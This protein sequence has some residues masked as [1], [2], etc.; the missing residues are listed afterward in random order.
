M[1]K[2]EHVAQVREQIRDPTSALSGERSLHATGQRKRMSKSERAA[3]ADA[4]LA[5]HGALTE[6]MLIENTGAPHSTASRDKREAEA[7]AA[8]RAFA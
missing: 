4:L 6:K 1:S 5:E 3:I 7:R 2:P 8:E